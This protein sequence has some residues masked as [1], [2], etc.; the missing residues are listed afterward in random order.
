MA[1]IAAKY[2]DHEQVTPILGQMYESN[3]VWKAI[4]FGNIG[5]GCIYLILKAPCNMCLESTRATTSTFDP[6]FFQ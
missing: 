5:A 2:Y 1:E 4:Q 6:K 3:S